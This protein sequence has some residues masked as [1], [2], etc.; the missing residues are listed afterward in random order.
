[1][2][3]MALARLIA[4]VGLLAGDRPPELPSE[5]RTLDGKIERLADHAGRVV[6]LHFW[7]F[8]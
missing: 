5:S 3:L 7:T 6:L 8:G 4:L 2:Q 1:M